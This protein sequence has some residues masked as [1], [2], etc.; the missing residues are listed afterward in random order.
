MKKLIFSLI[1]LTFSLCTTAQQARGMKHFS[2]E[3][4]EKELRQFVIK[5]A[6]LTQAEADKFFPLYKEM[7]QQQRELFK[8]QRA[9]AHKQPQTDAECLKAIRERDRIEV[10][11]R[12]I[13]QSYHERFLEV[14]P[15]SKVYNV[16]K[17]EDRFHRMKLRQRG[18]TPQK[19]EGK[20]KN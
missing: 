3:K 5:H 18:Q 11:L 7:Q 19:Q 12:K 9:D 1:V 15:A 17:A 8:Q 14:L 2:P 4:F 20:G 6:S 13:Q 10:E 16:I